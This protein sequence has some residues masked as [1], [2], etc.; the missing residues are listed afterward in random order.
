MSGFALAMRHRLQWFVHLRALGLRKGDD[1]PAYTSHR[2]MA[3]FTLPLPSIL[4]ITSERYCFQR[5]LF[6]C[7]LKDNLII[8]GWIV[9][10]IR[11]RLEKRWLN[12]GRNLRHIILSHL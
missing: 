7:F 3:Y 9:K 1:Q 12:L 6:V 4:I 5:R 10:I 2:G 8:V 11:R